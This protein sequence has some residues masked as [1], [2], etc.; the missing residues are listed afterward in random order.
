MG[1]SFEPLSELLE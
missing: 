1:K